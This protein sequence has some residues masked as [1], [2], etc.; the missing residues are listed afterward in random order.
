[1]KLKAAASYLIEQKYD[2]YTPEQ[3]AARA[4]LVRR[5]LPQI[6]SFARRATLKDTKSSDSRATSFPISP[7]SARHLNC[8]PDGA[9]P[10]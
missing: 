7:R 6:E 5:R 10:R 3:H 9:Q 1:M 2:E 4:E 8:A